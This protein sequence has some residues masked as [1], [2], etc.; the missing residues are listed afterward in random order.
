MKIKPLHDNI[1]VQRIEET[2]RTKGGI[3][4]PDSAKEKPAE[5]KV[6]A[7]GS[8]RVDDKGKIKPLDVKAGDRILFAKYAGTEV[9]VGGEDYLIMR[10]E[11]VLALIA[12]GSKSKKK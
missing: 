12:G 8:G 6:V 2:E 7:V 10:E 3:Y 5:G 9:S 4:I 11:D 1:L